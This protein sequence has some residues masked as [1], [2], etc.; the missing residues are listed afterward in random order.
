MRLNYIEEIKQILAMARQKAYTAINTAMVEA[1]WSIGKRI[2]EEQQHGNKRAA[3][4]EGILIELSIELSRE[5]GKGFNERELRR[6]RQF[7]ITFPKWDTLRPELSWSHYR[8]LIRV[9]NEKARNY[10]LHEAANQHWS[11]RTLE[12]NYNTLYYER[13]LS[14]TEK[15]IVKDEMHQK[16]DSYQLDKLEFIKNPYVLEFLQLTPATQYT[17]N[18]LEQAL[19]DNLQ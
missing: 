6:F 11:Y 7:F 17:E 12:R 4:G 10:Y 5:F 8:L 14:S 3:Y 2:V 18:Q 15:D 1:Y 19:L 16:T 9:L 13:L